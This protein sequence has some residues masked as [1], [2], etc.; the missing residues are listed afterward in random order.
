MGETSVIFKR[1]LPVSPGHRD[2]SMTS[3]GS[4]RRGVGGLLNM[5]GGTGCR[6][7]EVR[8]TWVSLGNRRMDA[9]G[10][11]EFKKEAKAIETVSDANNILSILGRFNF[12]RRSWHIY[13]STG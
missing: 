3:R 13:L 7:S 12:I 4:S 11:G 9:F 1:D 6:K 8:F 10:R 2:L 5:E